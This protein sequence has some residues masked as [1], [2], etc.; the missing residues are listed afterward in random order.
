MLRH[1]KCLGCPRQPC[2]NSVPCTWSWSDRFDAGGE[3]RRN[4]DEA[5]N[6]PYPL[7]QN[8]SD[9]WWTFVTP[10]PIHRW[11]WPDKGPARTRKDIHVRISGS[12]RTG[13]S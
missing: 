12:W 6:G 13:Q 11:A 1:F 5:T 8:V 7:E 10:L 4:D 3:T 9:K 2:I